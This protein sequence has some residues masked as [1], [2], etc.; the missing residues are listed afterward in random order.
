MY[1]WPY[2]WHSYFLCSV[3]AVFIFLFFTLDHSCVQSN[4]CCEVIAVFYMTCMYKMNVLVSFVQM[5]TL[6]G[7]DFFASLRFEGFNLEQG[8]L[9][10]QCSVQFEKKKSN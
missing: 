8:S 3:Y 9:N 7:L 6:N 1:I 5:K 2:V 10:F 4:F